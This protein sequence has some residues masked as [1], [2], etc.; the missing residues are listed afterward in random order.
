M[1][2]KLAEEDVRAR[3]YALW[4]ARGCPSGTSDH[5]WFLAEAELRT[6]LDAAST[7]LPPLA[8]EAAD[9]L[10]T[11]PTSAPPPQRRGRGRAKPARS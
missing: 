1:P 11:D 9:V 6:E 5:D 10:E 8:I 3:A 7:P 4:K 2:I